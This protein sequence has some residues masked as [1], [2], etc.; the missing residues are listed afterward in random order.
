MESLSFG[1]YQDHLN[2]NLNHCSLASD[3]RPLMVN[4]AGQ[5]VTE[6]PFT[7]HNRTGR[8]DYYLMHVISGRLEIPIGQTC[9]IAKRG[10]AIVFPPNAPYRYT[11]SGGDTLC[12]RWVHFTGSEARNMLSLCGFA[13][14]PAVHEAGDHEG[15][16]RGFAD[17]FQAFSVKDDFRDRELSAI[18][19][20]L[21]ISLG[22]AVRGAGGE[23]GELSASLH[24][25]ETAYASE[26]RIPALAAMEHLSTPRYN[27]KFKALMGVSPTRYLL[28][29][30]MGEARDLL[31]NTDF[32]VKE[33]AAMC[34][35][36]DPYFFSRAFK[37][38]TG[39][40]PRD[41]RTGGGE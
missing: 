15:L 17:L 10:S 32:S 3:E 4:C 22:R 27:A 38:Y 35:Y 40:S 11:F 28:Q 9:V 6:R 12:Y 19:E 7:T 13:E 1:A 5:F 16:S 29:L 8:L 2:T 39:C 33:I 36:R 25:L 37:E 34:G 26:I 14:L 23:R 20:R 21:L 31:R 41:F 18:F 30:R 24:Y